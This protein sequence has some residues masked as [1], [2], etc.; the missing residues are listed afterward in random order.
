MFSQAKIENLLFLDIETASQE[1]DFSRLDPRMAHLWERKSEII[2]REAEKRPADE[3]YK[4]R[5]AIYAEFG[6]VVCVSCG[7]VRF[8]G[9]TPRFRV[10]SFFGADELDI[11]RRFGAMLDT[12]MRDPARVLCAHNGKEFDF[13]Y[14]GRRFIINGIKLPPPLDD[15]Q[16]KKPWEVRLEDT[17]QLWKF[18]DFK[19]YTSL[20]LLTAVLLIP[21][22]KDD[23]DGSMVGK[24]Y[25][26][27]K[28]YARIAHYC[29]KDVIATAQVVLRFGGFQLITPDNIEHA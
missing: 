27:D 17:M 28:D 12:Y 1:P 13:P 20:D 18:G 21:T 16:G 29:E 11:L 6:R 7:Y 15:L 4:E 19:S 26:E 8:E 23:M 14:L 9:D 10:K 5:A 24:V 22:P 25:W 3:M 2:Q